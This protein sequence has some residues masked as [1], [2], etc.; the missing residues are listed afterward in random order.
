MV[1]KN[2]HAK[3]PRDRV[4]SPETKKPDAISRGRMLNN[5]S[6]SMGIVRRNMVI[7]RISTFDQEFIDLVTDVKDDSRSNNSRGKVESINF[8]LGDKEF[9]LKKSIEKVS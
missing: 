5:K 2:L 6:N 1:D 3:P 7:P 9:D 4:K 8:K